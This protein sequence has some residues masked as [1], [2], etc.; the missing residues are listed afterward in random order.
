MVL[1][2]THYE[3][4]A[5]VRR[6]AEA[7]VTAGY[8]VEV[9]ALQHKGVADRAVVNG[10]RLRRLPVE[11]IQG[12]GMVGY[13]GEYVAFVIRAAF[14]VTRAA[15]TRRPDLVQVHTLPDF[16]VLAALP[17]KLLGVPILLDMHEAM[18]PF[19]AVRFPRRAAIVHGCARLAEQLA[20][21]LADHVITVNSTLADRL[22]AIGL[23]QTK[24]SVV[25]NTPDPALF[26]PHPGRQRDFMGDGVLRLGYFG[27]LTPL[28]DV[29][30]MVR[31][32]ALLRRPAADGGRALDARLDI[33]GRGDLTVALEELVR[34]VGVDQFVTFHG[35]V[36]LD[37]VPDRLASVD[38]G[39]APTRRDPYTEMSLSTKLF[40]VLAMGKPVVA[41][42]LM[43]VERYVSDSAA[44]FYEAGD[45]ES[46]ATAIRMVVENSAWRD[47]AM[48]A[49][50]S[51][52]EVHGW[53]SQADAYLRLVD[54]MA[55]L[56]P[57]PAAHQAGGGCSAPPR[58]QLAEGS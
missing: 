35:R 49:G 27:S 24:V 3:E 28:Y 13:L 51:L 36:P 29:A 52:L 15:S 14:S 31:A 38:I 21:R 48:T 26:R 19:F 10:V 17:L 34:D 39:L 42:R 54:T 58:D 57:G 9:F 18:P 56:P 47:A 20:V 32:V 55:P 2:H 53:P 12:R 43:T 23:D 25:M 22:V 50:R 8:S 6:E 4:D 40:E 37:D 46:A 11:H 1:A 16:L 33:Y 7:L 44:A 45:P 41:T 30:T 5:R